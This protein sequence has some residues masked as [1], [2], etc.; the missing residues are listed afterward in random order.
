MTNYIVNRSKA[1]TSLLPLGDLL[2]PSSHARI[3]LVLTERLINIPAQVVPPM[4]KMLL[5]EISWAIDE[6]EPYEF[7][8]YLILSKTYT[9]ISSGLDREI[10]TPRKKKKKLKMGTESAR[11]PS[12][13]YF[14]AEV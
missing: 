7:S 13:F 9:E 3:G 2:N 6:K 10:D 5:E 12:V 11:N 8:H 14:H 1:N 4:Y